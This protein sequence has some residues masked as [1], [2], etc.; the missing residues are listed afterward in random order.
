MCG[1]VNF[2]R[3]KR[4][5]EKDGKVEKKNGTGNIGGERELSLLQLSRKV[6]ADTHLFLPD[7]LMLLFLCVCLVENKAWMSDESL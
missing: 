3:T 1:V 4:G 2:L 5:A 7:D 6:A